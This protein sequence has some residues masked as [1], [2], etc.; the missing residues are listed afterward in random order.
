ME[1]VVRNLK[2]LWKSEQTLAE[3][4]LKFFAR[5]I[6]L[7]MFAGLGALFSL[8]MLNMAAFFAI[9]DTF[10]NA[11]AAL[12]I[13]LANLL[14]AAGLLLAAQRAD[15]GRQTRIVEEVRDMALA[16]IEAEAKAVQSE[17]LLVRNEITDMRS[18]IAKIVSNPMDV[19]SPRLL[20]PATA[21]LANLI[22][23]SGKKDG[24]SANKKPQ[25]GRASAT[26]P[27]AAPAKT[28]AAPN[29]GRR[30]SKPSPAARRARRQST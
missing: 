26:K 20:L 4:K 3:I 7:L 28:K 22:M 24:S 23:A 10:G 12:L 15:G 17:L 11:I 25:K 27:K 1:T 8:G 16:D 19:L 2:L 30:S 9:G 13:G 14:L 18:G 5:K 29:R 21:A 6:V